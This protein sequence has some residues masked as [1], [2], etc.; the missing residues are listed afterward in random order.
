M[1]LFARILALQLLNKDCVGVL[2]NLRVK[3]VSTVSYRYP[4]VMVICGEPQ[5]VD[6]RVDTISNPILIIEVLSP[7]T[8]LIDRNEKLREYRQLNT[9]QEYLLVTQNEARIEKFLRRDADTWLYKE[10]IG[11]ENSLDLPSIACVLAL[12]DVYNKLTLDSETQE[13]T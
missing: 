13:S 11:L 12:A 2:T 7:G 5:F 3:V 4:D 8:A 6:K 1:L 10:T 9:V